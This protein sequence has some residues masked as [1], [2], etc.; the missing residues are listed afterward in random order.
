MIQMGAGWGAL[1]RL[2]GESSGEGALETA[3]IS[4]PEE[5]MCSAQD[6]WLSLLRT[7]K[8][9]ETPDV[10]AWVADKPWIDLLMIVG[11][12]GYTAG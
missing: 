3:G 11:R 12:L 7:G 1:E 10:S 6:V 4:F 2:R 8:L 9:P 5:S